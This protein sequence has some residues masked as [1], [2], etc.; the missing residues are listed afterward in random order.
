MVHEDD[1]DDDDDDDDYLSN[2][3]ITLRHFTLGTTPLDE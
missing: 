2:L 3:L 1:D